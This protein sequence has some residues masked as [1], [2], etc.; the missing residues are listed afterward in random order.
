M[1]RLK[2]IFTNIYRVL[3]R[4][5]AFA[6][7]ELRSIFHQPRLIFSLILGPFLILLIFGVGHTQSIRTLNTLFVAP[8]EGEIARLL[9]L[10][11]DNLPANINYVGTTENVQVADDQLRW[12]EVDLVIVAPAEPAENW[13]Q[14][15]QAK[16]SFY[17][18]EIDPLEATYVQIVG[19]RSIDQLNK[20]V[21]T[22]VVNRAKLNT[23][24]YQQDVKV[25]REQVAA[26]QHSLELSN[27]AETRDA[28]TSLQQ[29]IDLLTATAESSMLLLS[30][31]EPTRVEAT[32]ETAVPFL[33]ARLE[34][35][36]ENLEILNQIDTNQAD[37][38]D[39]IAAAAKI[40]ADLDNLD[41]MLTEFQETDSRVLVEPFTDETLAISRIVLN[42]THFYV[43]AVLALLLQ[44]I[45][46]TM[47]ALSIVR[48]K[49]QG[50]L[51][52]FRAA[53][54]SA[55]EILLGKYIGFF[56]LNGL[57]ATA[58]IGLIV[59]GLGT[60]MLGNWGQLSVTVI[61][62]LIVSMGVGF[63]LSLSARS[64]SQAIQYSM[65]V[66]L[67]SIFFTGLFVPL[68]RLQP[69]ALVVAWALPATYAAELLK[70]IMLRG[71]LTTSFLLNILLLFSVLLFVL[72]WWRLYHGMKQ[73]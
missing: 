52:L 48:E 9:H 13:R 47:A 45:A 71:Y 50:T 32:E 70:D 38:S 69:V 53:P 21:L 10:N 28:A 54:V 26:A 29:S 59:F 4:T 62:L 25:A 57:I 33:T 14:N 11:V 2:E 12:G 1:E 23:Q 16:F 43:P 19:R 17:H 49:Q 7:K 46:I 18:N 56:L 40:E 3:I 58:L 68:Y 65:I 39:E 73:D 42:P 5:L 72:A 51:E 41:N 67:A 22:E 55:F 31:L 34:A 61:A 37:F 35:I 8:E 44:H 64:D 20:I 63:N 66:L 30:L 36:Q 27:V 60:P 15:S 24:H 6:A